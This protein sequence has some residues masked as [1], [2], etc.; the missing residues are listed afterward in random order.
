MDNQ[1]S[2]IDKLNKLIAHEKSARAIGSI[3]EAET[4]AAKIQTL[5]FAHK[6]EMSDL[7]YA[8]E[9]AN[10]PVDS[11][12]VSEYDLTGARRN[13][14]R[15]QSWVGVLVNAVAKSN[16]CR[17]VGSRIGNGCTII[18]KPSDRT[19]TKVLFKYLY[20]TCLEAAPEHT[21]IHC[22]FGTTQEKTNFTKGFKFG[23]SVAIAER[24]K[25]EKTK[26]KAAAHEQGLIRI[27]QLEKA[28]DAKVH[29]EFPRLQQSRPTTRN[30]EGYAA[31]KVYGGAVGINSTKRLSA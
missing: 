20:D 8:A 25:V 14:N 12:L 5:M 18:G 11:E 27:D 21:R 29:E 22:S 17:T 19:A 15:S 2:M 3:E 4:F 16:F 24:L 28:V 23:F 13:T 7:E 26:L 1:E 10:E 30:Y 9:E 6:L 31:G